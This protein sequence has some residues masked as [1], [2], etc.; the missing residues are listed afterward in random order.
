MIHNLSDVQTLN[1]GVNT[2]VWQ[3]SIILPGAIIGSNC[4]INSHTF[5]ENDVII[6]DFVTVKSGVYLWDGIVI[7]DYVFIGPNVTFTNDIRPRSKQYPKE[8]AKTK[9]LKHASIG[10][11]SIIIGGIIIGEYSMIGAGSLVTKNVSARALVIGSPAKIVG[12][13]NNDGSKMEK[14]GNFYKDNNGNLW[15][16][17]N[18]KLKQIQNNNDK[19]S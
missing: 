12:W 19:I 3:Y 15:I 9:I 1:I 7:E 14:K 13:L 5:I 4:N 11:G 17:E 18:E 16:V 6:G 10:A 2:N 8:F